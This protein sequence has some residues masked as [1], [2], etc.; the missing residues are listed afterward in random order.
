MH[1]ES[2]QDAKIFPWQAPRPPFLREGTPYGGPE[3]YIY[4]SAVDEMA[5]NFSAPDEMAH[6]KHTSHFVW[7]KWLMV[8]VFFKRR[9]VLHH[10]TEK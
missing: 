1:S 3:R 9:Q 4:C 5:H 6:P 8:L 2:V 7:T 10:V